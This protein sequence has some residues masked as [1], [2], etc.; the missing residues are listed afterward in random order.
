MLPPYY[1]YLIQAIN[2]INFKVW[3]FVHKLQ[4]REFRHQIISENIFIFV[5][6]HKR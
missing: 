4:R 2:I 5:H 3:N 1:L 6:M